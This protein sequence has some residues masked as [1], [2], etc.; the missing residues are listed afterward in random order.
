MQE[1][2]GD[3]MKLKKDLKKKKRSIHQD[4]VTILHFQVLNNPASI[5]I[6]C[7]NYICKTNPKI[8]VRDHNIPLKY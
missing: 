4:A 6:K 2:L 7:K 1:P 3:K 5:Y 8:I